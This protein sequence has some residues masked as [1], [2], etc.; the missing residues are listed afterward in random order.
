M[1]VKSVRVSAPIAID[2]SQQRFK[3]LAFR[4]GK[5]LKKGFF[6]FLKIPLGKEGILGI[7]FW[8]GLIGF[9]KEIGRN[10]EL[11]LILNP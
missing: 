1:G 4:F 9:L 11:F 2:L 5:A 10:W 6:P 7:N 8:G 3:G